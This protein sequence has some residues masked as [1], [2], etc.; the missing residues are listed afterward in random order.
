MGETGPMPFVRL[1]TPRE[2]KRQDFPQALI[3]FYAGNEAVEFE[4]LEYGSMYLH[5]L[6]EV[7]RI[8]WAGV[9]PF[10]D[11]PEGWEKFDAFLIGGG[12]CFEKILY[13]THAPCCQPGAI[14]ALRGNI[15]GPGGV[16]AFALESSLVLAANFS[17]WLRRLEEEGWWEY[18]IGGGILSLPVDHQRKLRTYYLAL[19]PDIEWPEP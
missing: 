2:V 14:L 3:Q 10:N 19:N 17:E 8:G 11:C 12:C 7:E 16:G 6:H 9:D 5:P 15:S 4:G 1:A 18:A 13:V